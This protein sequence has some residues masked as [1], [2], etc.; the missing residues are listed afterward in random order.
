MI[1]TK[2]RKLD[3]RH[4]AGVASNGQVTNK[5]PMKAQNKNVDGTATGAL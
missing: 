4:E 1:S 5:I 2:D 3:R